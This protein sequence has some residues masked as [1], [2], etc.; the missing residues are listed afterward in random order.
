MIHGLLLSDK[1]SGMTSHDL[2][3]KV[4]RQLQQKEVGHAG[5]LDPL[6]TG[7]M[8]ML[9]GEATK[10]SDYVLNDSKSYEVSVRLGL[11]TD[12]WDIDGQVLHSA[13]VI[14]DEDTVRQKLPHLEGALE[15]QVPAFSAVKRGG[16][17][18]YE[19]AREKKEFEAPRRQMEFWDVQLISVSE[20]DVSCNL[21]C[22]KGSFIRSWAME[23]GRKLDTVGTVSQLRRTRSG[24]FD[25][26]NAVG[27]EQFT[28]M[29]VEEIQSSA[30]F[31][32]LAACLPDWPA[33]R[34]AGKE[35][36]LI[37]NGQVPF[38]MG[39]RLIVLQKAANSQRKAFGLRILDGVTEDLLAL[40][41][42]AP[43][44]A[45]RV[46]RVFKHLAAAT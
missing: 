5:T 38:D 29:A 42:I 21:S 26:Q 46:K 10:I 45:A 9:L 4:R 8:V 27:L 41:E 40:V 20:S 23:L 44:R 14:A 1:P 18:L 2:V 37:E 30:A 12:S 11:E 6:A 31:V 16:K 43:N 15:L 35:R 22:S 17:K 13:P 33:L 28:S 25:L 3:G 34:V 32:P 36:R 39:R 24:P 19:L 7:L